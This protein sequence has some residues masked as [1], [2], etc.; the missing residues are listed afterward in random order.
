MNT[1]QW[2]RL[3]AVTSLAL[4]AATYA[5]PTRGAVANNESSGAGSGTPGTSTSGN[6]TPAR[7]KKA[8]L[9]PGQWMANGRDYGASFFSPLKQIN[10]SSV[11]RLGFAWQFKTDTYR[12]MEATPLAVDGVL[13]V[14][15][16]WG[17][18]YAVDAATG[19]RKWAFTPQ[20]DPSF[21]RWANVDVTTR[22]LAVWQGKVYG[23]A[24]DCRV[25]A[26]N[27]RSG[28][29][30]WQSSALP[31]K[32]TGSTCS[33]A[34]QIAGKVV[35][36][37]NSGGEIGPGGVR[38]NV[39]AFD[40]DTGKLAW[41]FYTVPSLGEQD[42]A[43]EMR[44]AADTWDPKR[45]PSFGGGGTVWGLM[46]YDPNLDLVY[47]GTGN[48]APWSA[49]RD[50]SGGT[51][52]DRLYAASIIAL[53]ATSGRMAWYYQT[54]PG[55][56]WDF[57][58][59]MNVVLA[60]LKIDGAERR[61]L[62]Q[63][64]KNGY[65]Y[66][67]DR[68]TGRPI[69]ARAFA[70]MNWS[71][72]VDKSFRPIV[73]RDSDYTVAP[74]IVYPSAVGAH[75]WQPMSYSAAAGL[76]YI[77]AIET[78]NIMANVKTIP[79]S[80]LTDVDG[81]TGVELIFPDDMLSYSFWEAMFGVLPKF[82]A[83]PPDGSKKLL[84]SVLRAWDPVKGQVV[85]EQQTSQGYLVM[86]GGALS[87]AG[88]LVFAGREDGQFVVYDAATGQILKQID[89]GSPIMAAPM[90]YSVDGKQYVAVLCG[91]GGQYMNFLGTSS[92]HYVNEGRIL[93]FALDGAGDVP[94]PPVRDAFPYRE[95]P[96]RTGS[97][98]LVRAGRNLF[99]N[100]CARCHTLGVPAIS[101]DLSRSDVVA[102]IDAFKVVLLN[103][104]L[105]SK[106]MPRF[107][108]VLSAGDAIA[109]QS[110]FIDQWWEG[111]NAQGATK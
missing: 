96:A 83:A 24:I 15:G 102:S 97:P 77:P 52:R 91:H 65:F 32:S 69:S 41:R 62:L 94:K 51:G 107:D 60:T 68:E 42:P 74:K 80:Q 87:T 27:A 8:D 49:V 48:A 26:L 4:S 39:S 1:T 111:Y 61:V 28:Q 81:Q 54:T 108:D 66:V 84:R 56:I 22:G 38:G 46:A 104:A 33:G 13:Y 70:Y 43:P 58:S 86:D 64:N 44:R 18:V 55:D 34:P 50:W 2:V 3:L 45:D 103:G 25:F 79:A 88:G 110:Y 21:A 78:G 95:P 85:W 92:L 71:T 109:L 19:A 29:I 35:V 30:V 40:L 82:P 101:P 100:Y 99:F 89:T 5:A 10:V 105:L 59:T 63:A 37:G 67:L 6:V 14:S 57:D 106:G 36:V 11:S 93:A 76:V 7:L 17:T 73:V 12:G 47:F 31:A 23:I 75:S 9:E 53:H 90:T 16:N 20:T 98:E 72:G